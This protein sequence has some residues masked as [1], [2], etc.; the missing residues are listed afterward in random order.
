[1]A[2]ESATTTVATAAT[3]AKTPSESD[4]YDRQIRLW[5]AEAQKKMRNCKILYIHVTGASSEVIKNLVLAGVAATLCDPRP[6]D[7]LQGASRCFF[8]PLQDNSEEGSGENGNKKM[9]YAS[10]AH[11]AQSLVE[12]L[13]PLLG[14]CPLL[15][16]PVS[17]LDENDLKDFTVVVASQIPM[18]EAVR[19]SKIV[20]SQKSAFYTAD[21]FGMRGAAMIDL[22]GDFE[23]RAEVGKKLMDPT[24]LKEY[25]P[26]STMV[27]VPLHKA[28]NRFHKKPPITWIM[29]RSML[30]Y[31]K[32]SNQWLGDECDTAG[33]KTAIQTFLKEQQVTLTDQELDEVVVS[34]IA[35][36]APVCAVLGGIIGNEVIK[37]ITGKGEPANNSLLFDA[38]ACKVW[39]FLVKAK[40]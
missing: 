39:T 11:A 21:C 2:S 10:A 29:Y 9:K 37:I 15:A 35:Q 3:K 36:V 33:A 34:G 19:I 30:E 22:G 13:N 1:M 17:E 27:D 32:L 18:E 24:K 4:V 23:Y 6:A 40:E 28:V 14:S 12:E 31:Q 7:V 20:T 38:D 16:K 5:G 8:T 25:V 26:L